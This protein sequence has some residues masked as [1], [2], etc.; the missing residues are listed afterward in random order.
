MNAFDTFLDIALR[1]K[2]VVIINMIII[3]AAGIVFVLTLPVWY[4]ASIVFFPESEGKGGF[5][6]AGLSIGSIS[7]SLSSFSAGIGENEIR[8]ILT[9]RRVRDAYN[10]EF[11]IRERYNISDNE[12]FYK[13]CD[14]NINISVDEVVGFGSSD[15]LAYR[16]SVYDEDIDLVADIVEFIVEKTANVIFDLEKEKSE[17]L[18]FILDS[19][20][21][22]RRTNIDSLEADI[23]RIINDTGFMPGSTG[24]TFARSSEIGDLENRLLQAEIKREILGKIMPQ[25]SYESKLLDMEIEALGGKMKELL[26]LEYENELTLPELSQVG[27][28]FLSLKTEYL[29]NAKILQEVESRLEIENARL[30]SLI[31]PIRILDHAI[32]PQKKAKPSRRE[33]LMLIIAG[34]VLLHIAVISLWELMAR[35]DQEIRRKFFKLLR[36]F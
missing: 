11:N 19:I 34:A 18:I 33:L 8:T 12:T 13:F 30:T 15:I 9:S 5:G 3:V 16:L 20:A 26:G 24:E 22:N 2:R 10:Y 36:P 21:E 7:S 1:W 29:L 35:Q 6:F 31:S 17:E 28:D 14:N 4:Q 23:T 27:F 25:D 32:T